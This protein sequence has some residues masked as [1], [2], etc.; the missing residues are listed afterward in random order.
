MI[1]IPLLS[2]LYYI[3]YNTTISTAAAIAVLQ[4]NPNESF[5][6]LLQNIGYTGIFILAFLLII[7][8]SCFYFLNSAKPF[9]YSN[10]Y[11]SKKQQ[12]YISA[13]FLLIALYL[14]KCFMQTGTIH[15]FIQA[16]NYL[17]EAQDFDKFHK[18]NYSN[19]VIKNNANK[20]HVPSTIILVIGESYGRNF[21]SAYG[22]TNNNTTPWLKQQTEQH[23]Q[24]F[25][26]FNHAYS[27]YGSTVQS[28]ERALTEKNQYND[29]SFKNS[30]TL[31]DLA[32]K[33]GYKTYWFSNQ[34]VK[35]SADT[36]I[37]IVARTADVHH[38]IENDSIASSKILYDEDLLPCLK[39]VNPYENNFIVLHV[40]GCHELTIH[41]FPEEKTQFG[42]KGV[43][44]LIPNYEDAM[45]Y[46]DW[47]LQQ[48]FD[49][50]EKNLNL[51]AMVIFSDH[52]ANPYRKRTAENIPFINV[53][54]PLIIY[55]SDNYQKTYIETTNSLKK[56]AD[57]YFSNDLIFEAIGGILNIESSVI[58]PSNNLA[59]PAYKFTRQTIKTD[60]GRKN[61]ADD[62]HEN[63]I[64]Y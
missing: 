4:T 27:S 19:L 2:L 49:Y 56:N 52:G 22:Y 9:F 43:Y 50:A 20:S 42:K 18:A 35:N 17:S 33:A 15:S 12:L 58:N 62:I 64:E 57:K 3:Y 47:V 61:V 34:G 38:W 29:K 25:I 40:M 45:A 23:S 54:I 32:K 1:I 10:H 39:N 36:P 53:R 30:V 21:M 37:Q 59:N 44:D 55:L 31:L 16:R 8:I 14:P 63:E 5:E 26:K 13:L 41:R 7:L 28:L 51:D 11:L 60:L 46:N 48:V 6:Y 24:N